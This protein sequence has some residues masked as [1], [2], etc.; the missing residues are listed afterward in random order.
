MRVNR[1]GPPQTLSRIFQEILNIAMNW[2]EYMVN[3][4]S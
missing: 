3:K 2:R 1:E 4:Y